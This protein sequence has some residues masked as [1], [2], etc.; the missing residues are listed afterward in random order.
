MLVGA[1][2]DD[3]RQGYELHI[4]RT[5]SPETTPYS[6][7]TVKRSGEVEVVFANV[8]VQATG[9]SWSVPKFPTA[10]EF[11]G[12][13]DFKGEVFHTAAWRADV[14]LKGKRVGV[15][16]NGATSAQ[17]VPVIAKDPTTEV[18]NIARNPQWFIE[19]V[20]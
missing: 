14:E 19:R 15:I 2:W 13:D 10:Q 12:L 6:G 16:G 9:G 3:A 5:I 4:E 1:T 17:I 18:I 7:S 8:I 20:G 11:P